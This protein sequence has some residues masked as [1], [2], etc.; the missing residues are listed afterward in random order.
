MMDRI[1]NEILNLGLKFISVDEKI[2]R[3]F[4]EAS[5]NN[6]NEIVILP[7]VKMVMKKILNKLQNKRVYG[8]VYNGSLNGINVS[9]VRSLV[10]CPNCAIAIESLR[11]CKT[12]IIIRVDFCGGIENNAENLQIGD[13]IIPKLAYCG[14]GT[15]AQYLMKHTE[16]LNQLESIQNPISRFQQ[17]P[18]GND[19]I[20]IT[21]PHDGL[22]NL[23]INETSSSIPH[24][25]KEVDIWTT[26][27]LF[28]ETYDFINALRS[29]NTGAIDME[30]SIL[31]LLGK[32][33][34]LKTIS[35]LSVSD[36]P[37]NPK[38]DFLKSNE[39]SLDIESGIDNTIKILIK[40]MPKIKSFLV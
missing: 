33:Y 19:T 39:V 17:V 11:R 4:L 30:T 10:G 3:L 36:L 13:I 7:A 24:R 28:C 38:Y 26:D 23:L 20:F 34:N 37:G 8:R 31:F 5:P 1:K 14:D 40:S 16:L 22:K 35:F 21:K 9:V 15:S 6:V 32:L 12:K 29:I 18:T 2:V 25:V 27:A